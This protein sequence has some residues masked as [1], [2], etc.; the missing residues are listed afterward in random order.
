VLPINRRFK[1][2][3]QTFIRR[4][5]VSLPVI[6][7]RPYIRYE[8]SCGFTAGVN[9]TAIR[10][11]EREEKKIGDRINTAITEIPYGDDDDNDGTGEID[12]RP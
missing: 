10:L 9:C 2:P 7:V 11:E 12:R 6:P 4:G 3:P 8:R 1:D 5:N